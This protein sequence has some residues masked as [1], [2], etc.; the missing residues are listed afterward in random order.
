MS[1]LD[2]CRHALDIAE[3]LG[4]SEE[5]ERSM[6]EAGAEMARVLY[7]PASAEYRE[8]RQV[9][10]SKKAQIKEKGS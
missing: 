2:A 5:V 7:G 10:R 9:E 6:S 8:W 1:R 4:S 3:E